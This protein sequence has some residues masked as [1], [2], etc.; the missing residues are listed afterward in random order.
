MAAERFKIDLAGKAVLLPLRKITIGFIAEAQEIKALLM[1]KARS[2][3]ASKALFDN[4]EIWQLSLASQ[5][6][7]EEYEQYV[8]DLI[9]SVEY[10]NEQNIEESAV[11]VVDRAA[12]EETAKAFFAE[13]MAKAIQ[14]DVS[15]ARAYLFPDIELDHSV[16]SVRAMQAAIPRICDLSLLS[17]E[18]VT[19][20]KD[21]KSDCWESVELEALSSFCGVFCKLVK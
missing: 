2:T 7:G 1:A 20:L 19:E 17:E 6:K 14:N 9:A 15:F 10:R 12:A 13:Q 11:M 4:Q 18:Q 3:S 16:E 21:L 5:G 8:K